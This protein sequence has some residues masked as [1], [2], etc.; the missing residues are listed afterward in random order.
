[1]AQNEDAIFETALRRFDEI[2]SA[3]KDEREQCLK[4]RRFYS[5][6]GAQWEP[7]GGPQPWDNKK[8]DL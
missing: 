3:V 1:M 5:I 8:E 2:Q 6:A 4:D 7:Y